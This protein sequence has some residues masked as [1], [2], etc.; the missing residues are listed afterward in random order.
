MK[1]GRLN[2]SHS[3]YSEDHGPAEPRERVDARL[4]VEFQIKRQEVEDTLQQQKEHKHAKSTSETQ[5]Q[6]EKTASKSTQEK[7]SKKKSSRAAK[8]EAP[9]WHELS[10]VDIST[11][12]SIG[13]ISQGLDS[14]EAALR[15]QQKGPNVI[16]PPTE[17]LFL[18]LMGYL[19]GGFNILLLGSAVLSIIAWRIG[20]PPDA[21]NLGLAIIL[22]LVSLISAGFNWYQEHKTSAVMNTIKKLLPTEVLALRDGTEGLI[23]ARDLVVGDIVLLRNGD[24]V[25]ADLRL[26]DVR[27]LRM[28]QSAL[29]GESEAVSAST[30]CT[31]KNYLQTRN[32]AFCGTNV[33]EGGG[34]GVVVATGNRTVMGSI[35]SAASRSSGTTSGLQHEIKRVVILIAV[36]AGITAAAVILS[37][38]FWLRV[39]KPGFMNLPSMLATVIGIVVAFLP[40]GL[41]FCIVLALTLVAKQMSLNNVVVKHLP[42]VETLGTV[43][44]IASDKTGT[45]TQNKMSVVHI[46]TAPDQLIDIK[47]ELKLRVKSSNHIMEKLIRFCAL[48]SGARFAPNEEASGELAVDMEAPTITSSDSKNTSGMRIIGD[49]SDSA[50]LSFAALNTDVID[51]RAEWPKLFE[52]PFNS[53]NKW[54]LTVHAIPTKYG[55]ESSTG[56]S[57]GNS[58]DAMSSSSS[59]A[60]HDGANSLLATH[61]LRNK[62][63]LL[64][65]G[66]GEII[67]GKCAR[68]LDSDG[69]IKPITEKFKQQVAKRQ[70]ELGAQGERVLGIGFAEFTI[71]KRFPVFS[72][73]FDEDRDKFGLPYAVNDLIFVGLVALMDPPREEVPDVIKRLRTA[74]VRVMMVTGDHSTTALSIAKNVGIVSKPDVHFVTKDSVSELVQQNAARGIIRDSVYHHDKR[75]SLRSESNKTLRGHPLTNVEMGV[76][77]KALVIAGSDMASFD[78][79]AWDWVIAHDEIVFARTTP[80]DKLKIVTEL[81]RRHHVVGVTG[82][83]VNDAPAL[84][85]A[86]AGVAM[87]A[88]SDV[89]KEA[90]DVILTDNNFKSILVAIE[91]GRLV[92]DNLTKVLLYLFPSGSFCEIIPVIL[93]VWLGLPLPLSAFLMIYLACFTDVGPALALIK[94]RSEGNL[95]LRPP[96]RKDEHLVQIHTFVHAYAYLGVIEAFGA[97]SMY[98]WYMWDYAKLPLNQLFLAFDSFNVDNFAESGYTAAQLQE[99]LRTAQ[100]VYFVAVVVMQ[101]GNMLATRT[102]YL[103]LLNSTPLRGRTQNVSLFI[104][105]AVTIVLA[106]LI[107]YVPPFNSLFGTRPIPFQFWFLPVIF[108]VA[109]MSFDEIRKVFVR[110]R[111]PE[112]KQH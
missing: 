49:A 12:L 52:V 21:N 79:D 35:A 13:D 93:N 55:V 37:W 54:M 80:E 34:R 108:S 62:A 22:V 50:I 65:K 42:T 30:A 5:S 1:R 95:M 84:R 8:F 6:A 47:P 82:D 44:V 15:L 91:Y 83:G 40:D 19:F 2:S 107:V 74:G 67:L 20:D 63:L 85:Q 14:Q 36:L 17:N 99:H 90:A 53:K 97:L 86:E 75:K 94:E 46:F 10:I 51:T 9:N 26:F 72:Q 60:Q 96:R 110:R 70:Q 89:A 45:L 109:L 7:K 43:D 56:S 92:F 66:A 23:P 81:Q 78:E 41:P 25:P 69:K 57:S 16:D 27:S 106:V 101:F 58:S 28:D 112:S 68:Y 59:Q 38:V 103:S 77:Q 11:S 61:H 31:D 64:M 24:R 18:K 100:S 29:T 4:S 105:M 88:G 3:R 98:F 111:S 71:D 87:G 33:V 102:Q 104:A 39:S 73:A 76:Q 32:I 48:C